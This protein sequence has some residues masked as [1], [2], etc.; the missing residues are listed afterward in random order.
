MNQP[1]PTP[2]DKAKAEELV[3]GKGSMYG[4]SCVLEEAIATALAQ[5]RENS[6]AAK[7]LAEA[8]KLRGAIDCTGE[9]PCV[10][11]WRVGKATADGGRVCIWH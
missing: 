10:R 1:K 4:L 5:A 11:A 8:Q 9:V 3:Y 7:L 2:A 6:E